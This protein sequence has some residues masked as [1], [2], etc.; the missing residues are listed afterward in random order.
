MILRQSKTKTNDKSK[1]NKMHNRVNNN[2]VFIEQTFNT[3]IERVFSAWADPEK[4]MKW[5]APDGCT[6]HFKKIKV[7]TG[8]RFH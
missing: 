5:Y 8:G 6:I 3:S 1:T 7:E 4:L 2:E